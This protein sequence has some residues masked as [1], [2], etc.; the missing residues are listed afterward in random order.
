MRIYVHMAL[1][2]TSTL[3]FLFFVIIIII[4]IDIFFYFC[5]FFL[6]FF[7]PLIRVFLHAWDAF[8]GFSYT[9][10][11]R[12]LH[13]THYT[14]SYNVSS[15]TSLHFCLFC[16]LSFRECFPVWSTPLSLLRWPQLPSL[17]GL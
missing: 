13:I 7:L 9:S 11:I 15:T 3:P 17:C 12:G 16:Y 2:D 10:A 8:P 5:F 1:W 14:S 6:L 4:Y